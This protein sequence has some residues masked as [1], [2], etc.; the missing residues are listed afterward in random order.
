MF[1]DKLSMAHS[2]EGRVPYLDRTVVEF[3]QRLGAGQKVRNGKGKW[4]HREVCRKFLPP[5]ILQRK[6]KGFAVNVIDSWFNSSV[7]SQLS[8]MLLDER[9]H[10]FRML[11]PQPVRRL[12]REHQSGQE[13]NHKLLFSL[14][15]LEQWMRKGHNDTFRPAH[16]SLL[17]GAD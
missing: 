14:V 9:S 4:I 5:H 16:D 3:A 1:A 8:E 15:M 11:E 17:S 7:D 10:I 13:D 12:L 2:L 6:K